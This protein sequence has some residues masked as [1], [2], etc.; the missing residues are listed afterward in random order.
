MK[1]WFQT[2]RVLST[3][4]VTAFM[5]GTAVCTSKFALCDPIHEAARDGDLAKVEAMLKEDPDLVSSKDTN[6]WTPLECAAFTGRRDVVEFLLRMKA[7]VNAKDNN[8]AT[9]LHAASIGGRAAI[10]DDDHGS[11]AKLLLANGADINAKSAG[12]VTP[13][14]AALVVGHTAIAEL[15]LANKAEVNTKADHD[16]TPLHTA[17]ETGNLHAAELLLASKAGV[18]VNDDHGLTPLRYAVDNDHADVAKLL[19]LRGADVNCKDNQGLTPLHAAAAKGLKDVVALLLSSKA[20]VN[21]RDNDDRTPL[22]WATHEEKHDVVRLLRRYIANPGLFRGAAVARPGPSR[23]VAPAPRTPA[24]AGFG[25]ANEILAFER[26]FA[27]PRPTSYK[28]SKSTTLSKGADG[29]ILA[30][31]D[32]SIDFSGGSQDYSDT[33]LTNASGDPIGLIDIRGAD[34]NTVGTLH[35]TGRE[36]VFDSAGHIV[37]GPGFVE[38]APGHYVNVVFTGPGSGRG[39]V[40]QVMIGVSQIAWDANG[41]AVAVS[42]LRPVVNQLLKPDLKIRSD[43]RSPV[44]HSGVLRVRT[45]DGSLFLFGTS[46]DRG[47]KFVR[48][49]P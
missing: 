49:R 27:S 48:L 42:G 5:V 25:R 19:L 4:A 11:V 38:S 46:F 20:N 32:V 29:R 31:G 21:A 1:G 41:K 12:G 47:S 14:H 13:L 7:P 34:G 6:G 10:N 3:F 16:L 23:K 15:L 28:P 2:R 44:V 17:A 18:N 40:T 36:A 39:G 8:D 43:L 45:S 37:A 22:D 30:A 9:P 33:R 35:I 24:A 26:L